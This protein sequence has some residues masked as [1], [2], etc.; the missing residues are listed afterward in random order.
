MKQSLIVLIALALVSCAKEETPLEKTLRSY[1]EKGGNGVD[2]KYELIGYQLKD[3]ILLSQQ[4]DSVLAILQKTLGKDGLKKGSLED[5]KKDRNREFKEFR[6]AGYEKDV[7]TGK[8]KDASEWCTEIRIVTEKADSLIQNW[9]KVSDYSY[10]YYYLRWWYLNR[11][12]N[13]YKSSFDY[14]YRSKVEKAFKSVAKLKPSFAE[15]NRLKE[16][17]Q[18]SIVYITCSHTYS[19]FNPML[20]KRI[21][22]RNKVY[23]DKNLNYIKKETD[24]SFGEMM[25]QIVK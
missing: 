16:L 25:Q 14:S 3:T 10:E 21:S 20:D 1:V 23:L 18:D 11:M 22:S 5:F 2:V 19:I 12:V 9:D 13:F 4:T 7:M 15:Y 8:L 24:M 17:P 6:F